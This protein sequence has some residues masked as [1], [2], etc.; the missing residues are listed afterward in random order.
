M[1]GRD[2]QQALLR[3]ALHD[4]VRNLGLRPTLNAVAGV[5]EELLQRH[6]IVKLYAGDD[7]PL[8]ESDIQTVVRNLY[9]DQ[10]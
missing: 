10:F 6:S 2:R 7:E 9:A 1:I 8:A 5:L 3:K 4:G